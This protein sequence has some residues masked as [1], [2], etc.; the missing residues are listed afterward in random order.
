MKLSV[1]IITLNEEKRLPKTL[2]AVSRVADEMVVV[3]SGSKDGTMKIAESFG[4][5][6]VYNKW[7][8]YCD[9]KHFAQ[10]RCA[11][12]W[13]MM[14]DADEVLSDELIDYINSIKS[15]FK[16]NA[17]SLVRVNMNPT[18]VK[19]RFLAKKENLIRLYNR[20]FADLPCDLMNKDKVRVNKGEKVGKM[21]GVMYHYCFLSIKDA[22]DKYNR[23]SS[24]LVKTA[25]KD[26]KHY[27]ILRLVTEFPRQ[28]FKYY[29]FQRF[30]VYG[31]YGFTQAMI[32]AYF[33]FLKV[34]KVR[35][36]WNGVE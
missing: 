14:V 7:V 25:I 1:Y 29:F 9:Q 16:Y 19:P 20:K 5:K 11:N 6:F 18:D 3:D 12:D 26:N 10:E 35:A 15:D 34:A 36:H 22:V 8:S 13:V 32:L 21:R 24:E 31:S 4:C 27:S 28:F 23:H 30:F 33:R 17:Y 2:E